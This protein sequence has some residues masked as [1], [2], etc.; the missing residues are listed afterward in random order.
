MTYY[1]TFGNGEECPYHGGWTEI[2]APDRE[3]AI[4]L[5]RGLHPDRSEGIINCCSVYSESEFFRTG[6]WMHG[7]FGH[8]EWEKIIY[9]RDENERT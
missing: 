9:W 8:R 6:M 4:G 3:T 5:F 1:F 7:N 2:T